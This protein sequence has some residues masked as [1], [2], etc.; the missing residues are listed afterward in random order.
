MTVK[1]ASLARSSMHMSFW[2]QVLFE[3]HLFGLFGDVKWQEERE[4][5]FPGRRL[6]RTGRGPGS[7]SYVGSY[8]RAEM[9]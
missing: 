7:A 4:I 3:R 2:M 5:Q 9:G 1:S 8:L 6:I